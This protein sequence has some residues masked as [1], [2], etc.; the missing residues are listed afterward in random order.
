M[1]SHRPA[2]FTT[3]MYIGSFEAS[4]AVNVVFLLLTATFFLLGIGD[5]LGN[6]AIV[7]MGGYLGLVTAL[8]A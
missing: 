2:V 4:V 7:C 5:V 6:D 8:T 1:V 3:Y